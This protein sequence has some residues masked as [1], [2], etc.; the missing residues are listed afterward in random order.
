MESLPLRT[1]HPTN[2]GVE[3]GGRQ[4]GHPDP[5]HWRVWAQRSQGTDRAATPLGLR[6]APAPHRADSGAPRACGPCL[7]R[8]EGGSRRRGPRWVGV[9]GSRSCCHSD[10]QAVRLRR[11]SPREPGCARPHGCI[12]TSRRSRA[13]ARARASVLSALPLPLPLTLPRP[14]PSP[15]SSPFHSHAPRPTGG[16]CILDSPGCDA[17][18]LRLIARPSLPP[19]SRAETA[20]N[21]VLTFVCTALWSLRCSSCSRSAPPGLP[22]RSESASL[23]E[24]LMF[25]AILVTVGEPVYPANLRRDQSRAVCLAGRASDGREDK[26]ALRVQGNKLRGIEMKMSSCFWSHVYLSL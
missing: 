23:G 24:F 4:E 21:P 3:R 15:H 18:E 25:L 19:G 1:L 7:G 17:E 10:A 16:S 2:T 6:R 9:A 14:P 26:Q 8:G 5:N 13:S 22:G 12:P 20:Q 11:R